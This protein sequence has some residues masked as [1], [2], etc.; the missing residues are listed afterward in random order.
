MTKD[1]Q[2]DIFFLKAKKWKE[3]MTL[4]RNIILDCKLNETYKWMHPCYTCND[5]NIVL[6]HG[7]KEYCAI[8]FFK[9]VLMKDPKK[10]LIQQTANVQDRRQLRFTG[11]D[12]IEKQKAIIKT[13]IKE[14]I[15]IEKSGQKVNFKKTTEFTMPEEFKKKLNSNKKLKAAFEKLTPGRQR[16]YLLHFASAKQSQTRDSRIEKYIPK[17][18]EGKGLDD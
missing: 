3:E 8:L 12:E 6:I 5:Q 17:I 10:I 13:Y 4:L 14:A 11:I 16:G 7:F 1:T 15:E 2:A 9:G 18:M